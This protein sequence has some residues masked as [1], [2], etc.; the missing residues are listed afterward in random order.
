MVDFIFAKRFNEQWQQTRRLI[1]LLF[2]KK[3]NDQH[4]SGQL[5]AETELQRATSILF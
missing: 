3:Y 2:K 1:N 4:Y 5:Q